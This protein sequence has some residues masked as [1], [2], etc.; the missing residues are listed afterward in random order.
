MLRCKMLPSGQQ[1]SWSPE[2]GLKDSKAGL[3]KLLDD[4]AGAIGADIDVDVD[5]RTR[6][7]PAHV[8][9]LGFDHF[10]VFIE[11]QDGLLNDLGLDGFWITR[12]VGG[13]GPEVMT[14]GVGLW[15]Y[16]VESAH[17]EATA[18]GVVQ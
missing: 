1:M 18:I 15:R 3:A 4:S 12:R 14:G 16:A 17:V 10:L 2:F 7:E 11:G 5:H 13:N 9:V 8:L 6:A